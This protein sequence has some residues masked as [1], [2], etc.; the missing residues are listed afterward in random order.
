[1]PAIRSAADLVA[2]VRDHIQQPPGD[3]MP[4]R[5]GFAA[6]A[7]DPVTS[8]DSTATPILRWI[9]KA[10]AEMLETGIAKCVFTLTLTPGQAEYGLAQQMHEITHA[11]INGY[12][13]R[14]TT[15]LRKDAD[16][17]GWQNY[18]GTATVG[19]AKAPARL[20]LPRCVYTYS[21]VIGFDPAPD[22]AYAVSILADDVPADLVAQ[23]DIP[24][25]IPAR[26]HD[27]LASRAAWWLSNMDIENPT[28]AAR[29]PGLDADWGSAYKAVQ[30]IA[31][32][33]EWD[34]DDQVSA[35]DYREAFRRTGY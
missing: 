10:Y 31:Q 14:Q 28:A 26:Y 8:A 9:N 34:S 20:G 12:P 23:T 15:L 6:D 2:Q 30:Q 17:P 16:N 5:D 24:Q 4:Y 35:G 13:L 18:P 21:D 19:Q 25:R 27:A 3:Q 1:M 29:M 7:T 32:S 33:R 22:Q 11:T